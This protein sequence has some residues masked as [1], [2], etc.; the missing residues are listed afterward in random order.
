MKE[1]RN[2]QFRYNNEQ[3]YTEAE[4]VKQKAKKKSLEEAGF[5]E[6][7][8]EELIEDTNDV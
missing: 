8:A 6:K 1:Q 4:Q 5:S 3:A 7:E 2:E